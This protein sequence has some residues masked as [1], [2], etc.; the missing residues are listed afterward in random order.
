M[1]SLLT[2]SG[3]VLLTGAS[4][5]AVIG[6]FLA[7]LGA[8]YGLLHLVMKPFSR[9]ADEAKAIV[10]DPLIQMI[11]TNRQNDLSAIRVALKMLQAKVRTVV[12]RLKQ[13]ASDLAQ[14]AYT[15][16]E[17]VSHTT[18]AIY[19]Q[20]QETEQVA[21]AVNEM[22]ARVH[23]VAG[24]TLI[25]AEAAQAANDSVSEGALVS[26]EAVSLIDTLAGELDSAVQVIAQLETASE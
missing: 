22:S 2:L 15:T 4:L 3:S 8:G 1:A 23:E 25:A 10:D 14:E 26:S 11:Y 18:D 9:L 12:K 6:S 17:V 5:P 13:S 20:Q 7:A 21:T 24:N 19:R 16:S